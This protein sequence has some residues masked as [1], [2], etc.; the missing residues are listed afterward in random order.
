MDCI[1]AGKIQSDIMPI[2]ETVEILETMD[3]IRNQ[4]GL[5]YPDVMEKCGA[6]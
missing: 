2:D 3:S 6:Q 5:K 1:R 4:W